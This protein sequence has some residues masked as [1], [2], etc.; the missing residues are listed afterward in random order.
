MTTPRI[1]QI[2]E[3]NKYKNPL[4]ISSEFFRTNPSIIPWPDRANKNEP[5]KKQIVAS[6]SI[7]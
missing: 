6:I 7:N 3:I 2:K 5:H 1:T 4:F